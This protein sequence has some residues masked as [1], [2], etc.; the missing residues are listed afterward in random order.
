MTRDFKRIWPWILLGW[1]LGLMTAGIEILV[2]G[3]R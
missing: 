1:F 3:M 2:G